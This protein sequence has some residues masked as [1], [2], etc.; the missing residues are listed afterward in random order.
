MKAMKISG[1]FG[2]GY[3]VAPTDGQDG[4]WAFGSDSELQEFLGEHGMAEGDISAAIRQ[5]NARTPREIIVY[6][7]R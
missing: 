1:T 4:P 6:V 7:S 5:L 2:G 3:I